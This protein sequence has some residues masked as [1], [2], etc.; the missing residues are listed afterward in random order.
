MA[1]LADIFGRLNYL[2]SSLQGSNITPFVVMD[3]V[4]ATL[5][6]LNFMLK[7]LEVKRIDAFPS[8]EMFLSEQSLELQPELISDIKQHCQQL[9]LNFNSYFPENYSSKNW[10]R[11]PFSTDEI[12]DLSIEERE[13]F[14]ELSC[15]GGLMNEFKT[16]QLI[17][18]WLKRRNKF[19]FISEKALK[20]LLPFSTSY[21]CETGF[22]AMLNIKNKYRTKLNLEPNLRLKLTKIYPDVKKLRSL[23][24]AQPSH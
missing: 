10:I 5:K 7:D 18:F 12:G 16:E 4:N 2:N 17:I 24:Q 15:D 21:L 13:Q 14:L 20:F 22:S 23:K 3:K 1:Y 6:K 9:I 19:S 11:N 8:L